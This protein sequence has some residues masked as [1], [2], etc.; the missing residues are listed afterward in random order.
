MSKANDSLRPQKVVA[1]TGS[2]SPLCCGRQGRRNKISCTSRKVYHIYKR[3]MK[4]LY[5][6]SNAVARVKQGFHRQNING[7][8]HGEE[9][10]V[11][12]K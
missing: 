12:Y 3:R 5:G 2:R 6:L 9:A 8:G 11:V 7:D 4:K 1:T 10:I